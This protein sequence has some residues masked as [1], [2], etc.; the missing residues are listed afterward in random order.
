MTQAKEAIV[1]T[2]LLTPSNVQKMMLFTVN[3]LS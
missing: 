2:I 3:A 1:K